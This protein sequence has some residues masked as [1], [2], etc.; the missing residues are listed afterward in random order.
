MDHLTV[1]EIM[2]YAAELKMPVSSSQMVRMKKVNDI[3]DV[4]GLQHSKSTLVK[5]LSGGEKKRLSIGM[6]LITNPPIILLDE[7]TSGLDSVSAMQLV[8]YV[9]TLAQEGRT[10]VSVIHQPASSLFQLFD[11][12]FLLSN[13]KCIYSGPIGELVHSLAEAGFHCPKYYNRADFGEILR[14]R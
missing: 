11:D 14:D 10:I 13:G 1:R 8:T 7:P 4:L 2:D 9:K 3:L 12:V 6:E 5:N